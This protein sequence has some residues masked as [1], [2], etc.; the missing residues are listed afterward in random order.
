M[1][2]NKA[3][4]LYLIVAA[5]AVIAMSC[6]TT[7]RLPDDEQLYTGIRDIEYVETSDEKMPG[8][9]RDG[10]ESTVFAKPNNYMSMFNCRHPFPIGL[11]VYNKWDEADKGLKGKLYDKLVE[12]PVLVSDVRPNLRAGMAE[13]YL[14]NNGYFRAKATYDLH[15]E[16]NPKKAKVSYRVT[17]GIPFYIDSIMAPADTCYLNHLVD[18]LVRCDSY[19]SKGMRY[20]VDSLSVARDRIAEAMR[21]KGYYYFRSDYI[22]Y[23]ADSI[24]KPG[25]VVIKVDLI[26]NIP[27]LATA[28]YSTGD[29]TVVVHRYRGKETP[30]T[31][32]L[33]QNRTLVQMKPSKL[34][35][36]L[37]PECIAFRSGRTFRGRDISRTQ[38]YF[39]RM[40]MFS[41]VSITPLRDTTAINP[42]LDVLI[43]CRLDAPWEASM[44]V[45]AATKSNSYLGP[46][47]ILGL[48]NRNFF[49]GGEQFSVQLTG[50][51]E[52]HSRG[53]SSLFNSYEL[54]LSAS[55]AFP[56]MLGPKALTRGRSQLNW[57]R[58]KV[59]GE[60]LRRPQFFEM[61]KFSASVSY[62]WR[63]RNYSSHSFTPLKVTYTKMLET[64]WRFDS[65]MSENKAVAQ[66]FENQ[67]MPQMIY[68]YNYNRKLNKRNIINL[69]VTLQESGNVM[70]AVW[71]A[72]GNKSKKELFGTPFSQFV[73]AQTQLVWTHTLVGS[74]KI[75]GRVAAGIAHAYGNSSEVP[76]AEQF[77]VGGANSVRAFPVRSIG[78]GR[79]CPTADMHDY[80]FDQTGTLK[81]EA[82]VE[83]RFPIAGPLNGAIFLDAGNIWLLEDDPGRRGGKFEPKHFI[84]DLATCTGIG[85][86]FDLGMLVLRGDL[87]IGIHYPYNNKD[88]R[89]YNM[90]SFKNSL[91][92]HIAIG[93]PF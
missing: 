26:D 53:G 91:G 39:S 37:I 23:K 73:K 70:A 57:T 38:S 17:P 87:G 62:D 60:L 1:H 33:G 56:R 42:T 88:G 20:S 9:L 31:F 12:E 61:A 64:S 75:V 4:I 93:Y 18:S 76:Y 29:I 13:Q 81:F 90:S 80:Y 32:D 36:K 8:E 84:E 71:S 22:G 34:R 2:R 41:S 83:Y 14:Q 3:K 55:L 54:G 24:M 16:K 74:H 48:T 65:I 77:Y 43:D 86:R 69:S 15:N 6:S 47:L 35:H 5:L 46:G 45:N 82:N 30:D 51:Y 92:F 68:T 58:F 49:G 7:R 40:G 19:L 59:D 72:C 85:L 50:A 67:F 66:S 52:W 11:W 89:Y 63:W 10:V 28:C 44:E 25:S 21:N 78:P 27:E 79:Y